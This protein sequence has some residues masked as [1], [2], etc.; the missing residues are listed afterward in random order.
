M[1]ETINWNVLI[2][3][4]GGPQ[5]AA[6][7]KVDVE[8]Y[9]KIAIDVAAGGDLTVNLAPGS[10]GQLSLV[11]LIPDIPSDLADF[12]ELTYKVGSGPSIPLDSPHVL[13]GKG[14]VALLGIGEQATSLSLIF[15]NAG[16]ATRPIEILVGRD[17]TPLP[18]P[19][20][21]P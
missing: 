5:I 4:A 6:A 1:G 18:E 3:V 19:A 17:A 20:P 21:A 7:G 9:D 11:V 10:A 15:A 2:G 12:T 13:L 16:T 14:A 8:A